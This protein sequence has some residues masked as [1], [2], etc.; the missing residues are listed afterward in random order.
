MNLCRRVIPIVFAA[1]AA[2]GGGGDGDSASPSI[3][4]LIPT[5]APTF[6]TSDGALRLGGA[7][8]HASFVHIRNERTNATSEG[9]VTYVQGQG[10][11]F[12]DIALIAGDNA[13]AA[14]ADEDGTG[15]RTAT[16]RITVTRN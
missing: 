15:R 7:I 12:G 13:V 3:T 10:T 9:F 11:W 2:C 6:T 14:V 8:S 1:L 4:I 5:P 16:A